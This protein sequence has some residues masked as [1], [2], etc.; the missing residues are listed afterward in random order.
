MPKPVLSDS[1]FNADD[2]A[3]AVL[4]EANLQVANENLGVSIITTNFY[5]VTSGWT[6]ET[7]NVWTFNSIV[8]FNFICRHTGTPGSSEVFLTIQDS[9][10]HPDTAH[11]FNTSSFEGDTAWH[12][13]LTTNGEF[14]IRD[15]FDTGSSGLYYIVCN[16][17]YLT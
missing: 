16:G 8:F 14:K 3:T 13:Q 4:A 12:V 6:L 1:L 7:S 9:D 10:Y 2:V 5:S 17:Q 11:V 15:P